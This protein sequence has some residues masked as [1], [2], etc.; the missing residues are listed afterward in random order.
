ML[1]TG[2]DLSICNASAWVL[3]EIERQTALPC[4]DRQGKSVPRTGDTLP[5]MDL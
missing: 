1:G 5:V 3:P 2:I 4:G